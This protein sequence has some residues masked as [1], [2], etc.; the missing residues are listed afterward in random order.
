MKNLL[1]PEISDIENLITLFGSYIADFKLFN[2]FEPYI[3]L[4]LTSQKMIN[5][6]IS[7]NSQIFFMD[8][9]H[10]V[11]QNKLQIVTVLV[12]HVNTGKQII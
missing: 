4:I 5:I 2:N 8:G 10:Q 11:V 3:S 6:L 1:L 12:R 9:T 7:N